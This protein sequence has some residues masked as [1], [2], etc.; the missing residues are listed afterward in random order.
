M[1]PAPLILYIPG[2]KP[3]PEPEL[4]AGQLRRCLLAGLQKVD[5]DVASDVDAAPRAFDLVSWTYDFYGEHRDIALDL[6]GIDALLDK[7]GPD[8]ADRAAATTWK[9]RLLRWLYHAGDRLPFLI[10]RLADENIALH[11][12][13][14]RR[15]E[16]NE[17]GIAETTRRH[18]KLP[19]RAAAAAGRPVLLLAHSMGSVI[20]WDALWQLSRN[21]GYR[22]RIDL[23]MT[24]GSPLGQRYIQRRLLGTGRHGADRYPTVIDRWINVAAVGELTAL[25]RT[26][27]R[28]FGGMVAAGLVDEIEDI[29]IY[30]WYRDHGVLNVHA[31]YGYLAH[32]DT[33]ARIAAWWRAQPAG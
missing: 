16:R 32:P 2:L 10:P 5:R 9:R 21:A 33:A 22:G 4:H 11:L 27:A 25:D 29:E 12:R 3:K 26:L 18:L 17:N 20:S 6:P 31:E 13:D 19:L 23:F 1:T 30:N 15:Y 28:D 14:L 7:P 24:L 8:D